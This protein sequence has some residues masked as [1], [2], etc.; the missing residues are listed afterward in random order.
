MIDDALA[1]GYTI[2]YL[3]LIPANSVLASELPS[4]RDP[5][6]EFVF[7]ILPRIQAQNLVRPLGDLLCLLLA[8]PTQGPDARNA[9]CKA[10]H[11][12]PAFARFGAEE[13]AR[14]ERVVLLLIPQKPRFRAMFLDLFGVVSSET[15]EL[16]I[17]LAYEL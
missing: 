14:I 11:N 13:R 15:A 7:T 3:T 5:L 17:L 6:I 10:I 2:G 8:H 1:A 16:D 9:M 4:L 12:A